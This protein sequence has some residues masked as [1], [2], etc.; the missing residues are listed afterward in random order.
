MIDHTLP[1]TVTCVGRP[2][3]KASQDL[4][5]FIADDE[6]LRALACN[7]NLIEQIEAARKDAPRRLGMKLIST[8]QEAM[9]AH[10]QAKRNGT[11]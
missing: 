6:T 8:P 11:S 9:V 5:D 1:G 4:L 2:N 7:K 10:I 3:P